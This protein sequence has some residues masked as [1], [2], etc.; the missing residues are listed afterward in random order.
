MTASIVSQRVSRRNFLKGVAAATLTHPLFG[1]AQDKAQ[2]SKTGKTMAYVGTYTGAVGAGSNGAG[3]YLFEVNVVTGELTDRKLAAD[4]PDPSWIVIHPSKKYL[5]AAN[6]VSDY[7]G[8][9]GSVSAFAI[10]GSTGDLTALNVMNSEGAGPCYLSTDASG[11]YVFVANYGGGSVAVLPILDGG[12][13]GAATDIHRDEGHLGHLQAA[14]A[15]AGSYAVSGHDAPH[16][17][18]ISTDRQGRYVLATDL[19][20]DR[21]Y[22]YRFDGASGKL[23]PAE[24]AALITLPSGD[25]P[26]HFAFHPNGNWLYSI[27][28][29]ASNI[30]FFNYDSTSGVLS[31]QQTVSTLP[32]GFAGTSFASEILVAPGGKVL[33]AGNRLH[34]SI[35]IFSIGGDGRLQWLGEA[36]TMGDYPGQC[37]IDPGGNFLYACNRR[38]D[39]ITCFRIDRETGMLSFTGQY[40]AVGSPASITFL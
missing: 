14:G 16:A 15:P 19:G 10:D 40:T 11:R 27:Q 8:S 33:Y 37:R 34:D 23:R 3:I 5:Y 30:V 39:S 20:Q 13:L 1:A 12:L 4:T 6:E 28:E 25:G 35:A 7:K 32:P 26:R 29:E 9:S 36:S 17:H 31:P 22:S 38:S 21:I 2:R 18:M 24:G